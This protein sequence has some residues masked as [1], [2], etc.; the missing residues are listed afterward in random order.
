[1]KCHGNALSRRNFLT[2]GAVGGLG[3]TLADYLMVRQAQAELVHYDF[4]EAK[5][6][7]CIHIYLPGG[8][9]HQESFDPKPF[10]P[11]EYRGEMRT[12]KTNTGEEVSETI[13]HLAKIADKFALIRS[14]S[15]GEAAHERGTHNMFTGYRPSPALIFPSFGSIISHQYG[16]RNNLPPY[17]CVPGQPNE[18][19]GSGY[20]S[21]SF[22]PFSLGS[23]PA[24]NGF[25]VLDLALPNGV[26][27]TRFARRRSALEA[28]NY[29]FTQRDKSDS[30][31]AMNTFYERAYNMISSPA[32]RD[33]FDIEKEDAKLRDAYGRNTA[34]QRLLMARRL[35]EAGVRMV[36]LTYGGWDMHTGITAGM[37]NQ[38]PALDQGLAAL[39]KDLDERGL[40]ASTMIMVSSEFG[41]TPKI[42][43][44]AGRDHWPKVFSVLLAGGGIEGGTIYGSS[45]A[46]ASEPEDNPVGPEDLAATMYYQMGI[47]SDKE[48]MAPGDRPIEIV[49]GGK[50]I[51]PLIG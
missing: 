36:T 20:L 15:H 39:I 42:N 47:I 9:A 22:A 44:T 7:S 33:A 35:V 27:E 30:I 41:R 37:R 31:S 43:A 34:G 49:D 2:V 14:M 17:V 51:K 6:Q 48:I 4:I 24:S 23:D 8:M 16:P 29:Y 50:V 38:M 26:D 11:I 25:K 13:P 46:T 19:A 10:S 18:F 21:S 45:N 1:M 32:A 5:A 40:L 28:V 12:I 3:L